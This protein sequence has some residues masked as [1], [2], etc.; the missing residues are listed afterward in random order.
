MFR[1]ELFS[2]TEVWKQPKCP[3]M[4]ERRQKNICHIFYSALRRKELGMVAHAYI[5]EAAGS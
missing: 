4:D 5:A 3:L 2:I 1:A